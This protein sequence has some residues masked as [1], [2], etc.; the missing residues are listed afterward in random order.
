MGHASVWTSWTS[1]LAVED[2][3][4]DSSFSGQLTSTDGLDPMEA[5]LLADGTRYSYGYN[6]I[7]SMPSNSPEGC[8]FSV[9]TR[10]WKYRR[11][12]LSLLRLEARVHPEEFP[13]RTCASCT[14]SHYMSFRTVISSPGRFANKPRTILLSITRIH[15]LHR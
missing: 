9:T 11:H 4:N 15:P 8:V 2:E 14:T 1:A 5:A 6:R 7:R 13:D 3:G 12:P 10:G